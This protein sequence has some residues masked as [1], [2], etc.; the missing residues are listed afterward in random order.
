VLSRDVQ[1]DEEGIKAAPVEELVEN[2]WCLQMFNGISEEAIEAGPA[3]KRRAT[4]LHSDF[5][6][7]GLKGLSIG[8][9]E[10]DYN[11]DQI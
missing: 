2:G 10:P 3:T 9:H 6:S 7:L 1:G 4:L 5:L 11:S 8:G